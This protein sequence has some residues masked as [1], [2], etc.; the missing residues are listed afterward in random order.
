MTI[1]GAAKA[2]GDFTG[3]ARYTNPTQTHGIFCLY[4]QKSSD[5][6][7]NFEGWPNIGATAKGT[8][9]DRRK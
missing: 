2:I 9:S 5:I 4:C 7:R 8:T 1:A 6:R 3:I